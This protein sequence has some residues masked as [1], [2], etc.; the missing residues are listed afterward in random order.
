MFIIFMCSL[1]GFLLWSR[2]R[3]CL[4]MVGLLLL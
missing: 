4:L 2:V 1:L 3:K